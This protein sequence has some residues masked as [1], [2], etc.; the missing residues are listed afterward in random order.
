MILLH[1]QQDVVS[2]DFT[3]VV[4]EIRHFVFQGKR[5]GLLVGK[6]VKADLWGRCSEILGE[7]GQYLN[8]SP[9]GESRDASS[10]ME[11]L[12]GVLDRPARSPRPFQIHLPVLHDPSRIASPFL[13]RAILWQRLCDRLIEGDETR[14]P[15][16]LFLENFDPSN[17]TIQHDLARIL[18]FHQTHRIRRSFLLSLS[19]DQLDLLSPEI[20]E[21]IEFQLDL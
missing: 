8:L 4:D 15:S 6:E 11:A 20:R 13:N 2:Y 14:R 19:K 1:S 9:D 21:L 16:L 10:L 12:I 17:A 3:Q 7:G 5:L 18:R